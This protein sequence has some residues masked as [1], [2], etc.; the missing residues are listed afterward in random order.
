LPQCEFSAGHSAERSDRFDLPDPYKQWSAASL[1]DK[2]FA[3]MEG[4][5]R[6]KHDSIIVTLYKDYERLNIE[7]K[8]SHM[9]TI[10]ENEGISL[11][12]PWLFDYKLEFRFK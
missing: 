5:I 4:D 2:A 7:D 8:Y 3:N 10:L 6:V 1:A 9:S 11:K 12:I